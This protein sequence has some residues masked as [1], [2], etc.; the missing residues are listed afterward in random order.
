MY[1]DGSMG[2]PVYHEFIG[3]FGELLR[4]N[5]N[6]EII[7]KQRVSSGKSTLQPVMLIENPRQALVLMRRSGSSPKRVIA[8]KTDDAGLHWSRPETTALPN[9]DAA[10]T[11]VILADG[12]ILAVLNNIEDGR[13]EL[14]LVLS[15]DGGTTWKTVFQF[16]DQ[17]G[18]SVEAVNY[19]QIASELAKS[20]DADITDASSYAKSAQ[21][22]KC[23]AG[24]CSYEFSYPYLIQTSDGDFQLVYTWNRSFIKHVRFTRKW[25]DQRLESNAGA[26]LH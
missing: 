22:N 18:K 4:M 5:F 17:H 21:G 23:E 3:K 26:T 9:P 10:I 24:R 2:L 6:G 8:T 12:R 25:L 1:D 14:S 15:A 19:L 7:D 20:T 16:E 11:A 13:D